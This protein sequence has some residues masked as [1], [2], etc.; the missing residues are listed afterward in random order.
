MD[1]LLRLRAR[2]DGRR[3]RRPWTSCSRPGPDTLRGDG[4]GLLVGHDAISAFRGGARR[5]PAARSLDRRHVR[6]VD[7]RHALVV[8][9]HRLLTRGGRGLQTQLWQRPDDGGWRIT[10]AHVAGPPPRF[11]PRSGGS[12]GD[13]L[14]QGAGDG[15][16]PG[17]RVAVKDLFA[18]AGHARRRREPGLAARRGARSR[19]TPP[20]WPRLLDAGAAVRGIARTDEF[21]YSL[22]GTNAHYGTP[23]NPAAP[24]RAPRRL[25]HGSAAAV[26]LGQRDRRAGHRH[27][28]LHPRARGLPGPLGHPH[29]ARAG[30]PRPGLLPL[31]PS[32]TPSAG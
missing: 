24:G 16:L 8:A 10:A 32:S 12:V 18:V 13:P 6:A 19:R 14:Y 20:R 5:A 31:A 15:P 27:R 2:A 25:V 28:R 4:D 23:P 21:A 3:R 11:D 30:R 9:R 29:H 1:G 26:A 22:A 7:R 17:S